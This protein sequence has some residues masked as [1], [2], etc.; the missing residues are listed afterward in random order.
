MMNTKILYK[1]QK[2]VKVQKVIKYYLQSSIISIIMPVTG[3]FI[4]F[5][6]MKASLSMVIH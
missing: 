6:K 5:I 2:Y 1:L 4:T 3:H